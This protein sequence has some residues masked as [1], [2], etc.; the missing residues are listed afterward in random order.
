MI[1]RASSLVH[2]P[3]RQGQGLTGEVVEVLELTELVVAADVGVVGGERHQ[4]VNEADDDDEAGDGRQD[5]HDGGVLHVVL[6][7][8]LDLGRANH[9]HVNSLGS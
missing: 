6:A 5:E 8:H 4:E 2:D 3:V 7:E 9:L 1:F